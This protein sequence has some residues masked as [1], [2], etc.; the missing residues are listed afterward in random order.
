MVPVLEHLEAVMV[1]WRRYNFVEFGV[2]VLVDVRFQNDTDPWRYTVVVDGCIVTSNNMIQLKVIKKLTRDFILL[3]TVPYQ[4]L[5]QIFKD[6]RRVP[7]YQKIEK[8][9]KYQ[10]LRK[11][12]PQVPKS[13][14]EW[15]WYV[16]ITQLSDIFVP[17]F[18][19]FGTWP[20]FWHFGTH[21]TQKSRMSK[22]FSDILVRDRL[23]RYHWQPN[24][25]WNPCW[26]PCWNEF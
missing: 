8:Y 14:K 16:R 17:I 2:I 1:Y 25:S 12:R 24:N 22:I 4:N 15:F 19:H 7:K 26:N 6:S 23:E 10:N 21:R 18:L 20:F 9:W 11:L 3:G 13:R 5:R